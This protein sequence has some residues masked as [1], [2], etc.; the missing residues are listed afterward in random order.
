MNSN[1]FKKIWKVASWIVRGLLIVLLAVLTLA[2]FYN[3]WYWQPGGGELLVAK[4]D[5]IF[6]HCILL[7]GFALGGTLVL[8]KTRKTEIKQE[9]QTDYYHRRLHLLKL[10]KRIVVC[11]S[12]LWILGLMVWWMLSADRIP[13]ADGWE[14]YKA[15]EYILGGS[16]A[17]L[18][19]PGYLGKYPFQI[20]LVA[21][22]QIFYKFFGIGSYKPYQWMC[23]LMVLSIYWI[24][25]YLVSCLTETISKNKSEDVLGALVAS[26]FSRKER[27]NVI[28]I[29]YCLL[30]NL[31]FPL[32]FYSTWVYGDIP[33]LFFVMLGFLLLILAEGTCLQRQKKSEGASWDKI[34][35]FGCMLGSV[36]SFALAVLFRSNAWICIIAAGILCFLWAVRELLNKQYL[37]MGFLLVSILLMAL[38]PMRISKSIQQ[39]FLERAWEEFGYEYP[40]EGIPTICWI[41]M[42]MQE[43]PWGSGWYTPYSVELYENL[44]YDQEAIKEAARSDIEYLAGE[45]M[46]KPGYA[47]HFYSNKLLT[48][49]NA[50]LYQAVYH[51][52]RYE[53]GAEPE[54]DSILFYW[55][56]G[57]GYWIL[58]EVSELLQ[59]I[60]FIG[61][62]LYLLLCD[63][64]PTEIMKMLLPT[65]ILGAM[66]FSLLWEAKSRYVFPFYVMLFPMAVMGWRLLW[67]KAGALL[68][69]QKKKG[70]LTQG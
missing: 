9:G 52:T 3:T 66:L 26:T 41:S 65:A 48:Q 21:I 23:I 35:F 68:I 29:L 14:V 10:C 45:F 24:G 13:S 18:L 33:F 61:A 46:R 20:P 36:I 47:V 63:I 38:V 58:L 27:K 19:Y 60:V 11:M 57:K 4:R 25:Y 56:E 12:L 50:P 51:N 31:C 30:M 8:K 69:D 43:S 54:D 7:L 42:G 67:E 17:A 44:H 1:T 34:K 55:T 64:M 49:W 32:Y 37:T 6:L 16:N 22:F 40:L 59:L 53:E 5:S 28:Q 15:A 2:A 62:F 39:Q 70:E